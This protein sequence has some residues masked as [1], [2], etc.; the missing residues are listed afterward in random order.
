MGLSRALCFRE[1]GKMG[2][3]TENGKRVKKWRRW[4][5]KKKEW[6]GGVRKE[7]EEKRFVYVSKR[8]EFWRF[9]EREKDKMIRFIY[10]FCIF[11]I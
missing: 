4:E 10:L 5:E 6:T 3:E 9:V 1:R 11:I 8:G 2:R 7:D